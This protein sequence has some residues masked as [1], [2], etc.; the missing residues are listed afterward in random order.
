MYKTLFE[1]KKM[2]CAAE[3]QLIRLKLTDVRGIKKLDFDLTQRTL[4][5]I[6]QEDPKSIDVELASLDLDSAMIHS[7]QTDLIVDD[8]PGIQKQSLWAVLLIN[9]IFFATEMIFG[10]ISGSMGLIADSLDMLADSIVYGL[11]LL[12]VGGSIILK[13]K[14]A[15]TAGYFQL[16]LAVLGFLEVVRRFLGTT[17][18][19]DH[20][21]MI[22]IS[23]LA[24]AGNILC[25]YILM[26]TK[27][28]EAHMQASMI[29]TSNDIIINAGVIMAGGLVYFLGS[30]L[31]D[32]IIGSIVF[33]LVV[34]GALRILRL[35]KR[36]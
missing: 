33:A 1:I 5:V 36:S 7:E 17:S 21:I 11:S 31:P 12:A 10:W 6:H 20:K 32:L 15:T 23:I 2:D 9:F 26:K 14:I 16:A 18:I 34:K 28:K 4:L 19:P 3:E 25:L 30:N 13:K 27:S 24:L 8:E 29:F 35:G 22:M